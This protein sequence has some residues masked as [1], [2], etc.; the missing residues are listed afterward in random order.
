MPFNIEFEGHIIYLKKA[1][2]AVIDR[3]EILRTIFFTDNNG[4]I[5]QKILEKEDIGLN[6]DYKDFREFPDQ[7]IQVRSYIQNDI[8]KPFDL[9]K[10]PLLRISILQIT[11]TKY[12]LYYVLHHII[13][14]GW[15]LDILKRDIIAYYNFFNDGKELKIPSLDIQYKD[16][17]TW[18]LEK[19]KSNTFKK[20]KEY[21][22]SKLLGELPTLDLPNCTMRPKLK[23]FNGCT[24]H[25]L[26]SFEITAQL[27][28]LCVKHDGSFFI[29]LL[30][31]WNILLYKLSLIHI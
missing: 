18:Q 2:F 3:H 5:K 10:G 27:K 31:A 19:L 7:K 17:A 12:I 20:G 1:I 8:V 28:S 30:A 4:I 21:W 14:D 23:T 9:E 16:Y 24:L 13:C 15:S 29:G 22:L 11:D 26:I 6:I 25:T